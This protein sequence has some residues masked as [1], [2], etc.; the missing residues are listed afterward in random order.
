ML[1]IKFYDMMMIDLDITE[2]EITEEKEINR[3]R[4]N[5]SY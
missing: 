5:R 3:E 1:Y 2:K 4:N